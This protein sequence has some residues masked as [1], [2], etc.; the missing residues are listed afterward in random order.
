MDGDARDL[1]NPRA[2]RPRIHPADSWYSQ[3]LQI[4]IFRKNESTKN[5]DFNN[6]VIISSYGK[7]HPADSRHS[8]ILQITI[9]RKNESTKNTDFNNF[10][11]ISSYEKKKALKLS[12]V[13]IFS[14]MS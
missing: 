5:T 6:F 12:V 10:V 3:I 13:I 11:I 2:F 8:Q 14:F 7:I 4:T 1:R 9:F